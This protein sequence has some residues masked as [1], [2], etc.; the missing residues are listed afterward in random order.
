MQVHVATTGDDWKC[1]QD[2]FLTD[3]WFA[4][5]VLLRKGE[6]FWWASSGMVG[7]LD[8]IKWHSNSCPDATDRGK[9]WRNMSHLDSPPQSRPVYP[10]P[11]PGAKWFKISWHPPPNFMKLFKPAIIYCIVSIWSFQHL[12][13]LHRCILHNSQLCMFREFRFRRLLFIILLSLSFVSGFLLRFLTTFLLTFWQITHDLKLLLK[14]TSFLCSTVD[15]LRIKNERFFDF[16]EE[17]DVTKTLSF[18]E[19]S[20]NSLIIFMLKILCLT[21]DRNSV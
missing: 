15:V 16:K 7:I 21:C 3:L 17:R 5:S 11:W 8:P 2:N 18:F 14:R 20:Y 9:Q 1:L 10:I 4:Y 13:L 19:F 12:M 6:Q